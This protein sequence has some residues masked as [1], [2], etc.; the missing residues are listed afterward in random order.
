MKKGPEGPN[1]SP[2]VDRPR[3]AE[4]T[5][6]HEPSK[7]AEDGPVNVAIPDEEKDAALKWAYERQK[8]EGVSNE[9]QQDLYNA[10]LF[11]DDPEVN[12]AARRSGWK[13]LARYW[14]ARTNE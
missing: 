13:I 12:D 9:E 2:H 14:H 7:L 11:I 3:S 1:K 6:E 10:T 5:F 8:K 4:S